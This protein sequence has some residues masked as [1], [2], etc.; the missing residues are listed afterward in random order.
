MATLIGFPA[1]YIGDLSLSDYHE[2][3]DI[4]ESFSLY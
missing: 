2:L 3:P 4:S 1:S